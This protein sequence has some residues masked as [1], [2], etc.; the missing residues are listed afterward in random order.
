MTLYAVSGPEKIEVPIKITPFLIY[1][2]GNKNSSILP[3]DDFGSRL[4]IFLNQN[5]NYKLRYTVEMLEN[6]IQ[7]SS[8]K[9]TRIFINYTYER[10]KQSKTVKLTRRNDYKYDLEFTGTKK[11]GAKVE[12]NFEKINE[13]S[14][15]GDPSY[16]MNKSLLS[17]EDAN[18]IL[19]LGKSNIEGQKQ[20]MKSNLE[21]RELFMSLMKYRG[22]LSTENQ[23][24]LDSYLQASKMQLE[25]CYQKML[26]VGSQL[27]LTKDIFKFFSKKNIRSKGIGGKYLRQ[28]RGVL[29]KMDDD[30][31]DA[32]K[33]TYD[34]LL[35]GERWEQREMFS[36]M[37]EDY[38]KEYC[39]IGGGYECKNLVGIK[40]IL[41]SIVK[42]A[43]K[44]EDVCTVIK[45]KLSKL[46]SIGALRE[47]LGECKNEKCET[48]FCKKIEAKIKRIDCQNRLADAKKVEDIED[49]R[50][51]LEQLI[52]TSA[53]QNIVAQAK[54]MLAEIEPL[55]LDEVNRPERFK[56]TSGTDFLTYQLNFNSGKKLLLVEFDGVDT[57]FLD[58]T[59]V[60]WKWL[61]P[62]RQ[63]EVTVRYREKPYSLKIYSVATKEDE[64]IVL[65][66]DPFVAELE[67]NGSLLIV[68]LSNGIGPFYARFFNRNDDSSFSLELDGEGQENKI[69]LDQLADSYEGE[70]EL[71]ILDNIGRNGLELAKSV[72]IAKDFQL[73]AW[74]IASPFLLGLILFLIRRNLNFSQD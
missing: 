46:N 62:D 52:H 30:S 45:K 6:A 18:S 34:K 10:K 66:K 61:K 19:S 74:M 7:Q 71:E 57:S 59:I 32:Y 73:V 55:E 64:L 67:E 11:G 35:S 5:N 3:I 43:K 21:A 25:D 38:Q 37:L 40:D 53:C 12:I 31:F 51:L 15:E 27:S 16:R 9:K 70:Y 48:S 33:L 50:S 47:L 41:A 20:Y 4:P 17:I 36:K 60:N 65:S 49:K 56:S 54:E 22:E 1:L 63:L 28:T 24:A 58:T 26:P 69:D 44:E 2:D 39:S 72:S 13:Y 42:P 14:L 8:N 68:T 23:A 29:E